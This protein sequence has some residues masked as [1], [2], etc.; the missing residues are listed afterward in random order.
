MGRFDRVDG[1]LKR[2]DRQCPPRTALGAF[3]AEP[4]DT[5][6]PLLPAVSETAT[7]LRCAPPLMKR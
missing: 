1:R 6:L 7:A 2:A 4:E 5:D 3:V